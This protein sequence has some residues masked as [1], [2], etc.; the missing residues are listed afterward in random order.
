MEVLG[1]LHPQIVH[2]PIVMLIFSA[3]FAILGRLFDRDWLRRASVLML[4]V[5][6]LGAFTAVRSGTITHEVAEH[7]Q[8]VPEADIDEHGDMGRITMYVSGAA[9][10]AVAVA[11]RLPGGAAQAVGGLA[12]L[13]QIAA[14]VFVGIAGYRGGELVYEHGAHVRLGGVLVKDPGEPGHARSVPAGFRVDSAGAKAHGDHD[15]D[16]HEKR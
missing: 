6:F 8:G 13:L 10:I 14:A 9:L 2:T 7:D 5:G 4:V 11:S 3:L 12:L 16:E 15:D 1:Q